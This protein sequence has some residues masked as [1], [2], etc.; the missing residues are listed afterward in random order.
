MASRR[1]IARLSQ[2]G[3]ARKGRLKIAAMDYLKAPIDTQYA[4][5]GLNGQEHT[6]Y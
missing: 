3:R 2:A 6:F 4:K 1:E 5:R